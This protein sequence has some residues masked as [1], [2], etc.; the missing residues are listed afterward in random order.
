MLVWQIQAATVMLCSCKD[1][2]MN[3]SQISSPHYFSTFGPEINSRH[4]EKNENERTE[5]NISS[6][7]WARVDIHL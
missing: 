1:S 5:E 7:F 4:S 6:I 3:T 2:N